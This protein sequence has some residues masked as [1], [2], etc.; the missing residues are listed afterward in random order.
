MP[1]ESALTAPKTLGFPVDPF[2]DPFHA[3]ELRAVVRT[4][5]PLPVVRGP[6]RVKALAMAVRA[7]TQSRL[8]YVPVLPAVW[9]VAARSADPSVVVESGGVVDAGGGD[10]WREAAVITA[11]SA[12]VMSWPSPDPAAG[13]S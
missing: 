8:S 4:A 1:R 6:V 12:S 9:E 3:A 11:A 10:W 2:H 7:G 5:V 13:P